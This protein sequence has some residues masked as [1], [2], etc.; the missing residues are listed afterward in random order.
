MK[1]PSPYL[2]FA[3]AIPFVACALLLVIGIIDIPYLGAVA[4]ILSAYGLVI[5]SFMAGSQWGNHLSLADD[6]K[7][8]VR[9]PL[10]SNVIAIVLWL[11]FLMLPVVGFIWLLVIGFASMLMIDYGLNR[12]RIITPDYFKVRTYVT[13]IVVVSLIVAAMQ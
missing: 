8:A 11:G 5:A 13:A 4:D 2:T 9:L 12:A 6:D 7:W 3:G 10:V 1:K